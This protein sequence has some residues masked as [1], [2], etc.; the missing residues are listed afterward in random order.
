[1]QVD[2]DRPPVVPP[3]PPLMR[4]EEVGELFG[5]E[6]RQVSRDL[7]AG[8]LAGE[9]IKTP[10]GQWRIPRAAVQDFLVLGWKARVR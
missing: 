10:G 8:W 3:G 2:L 9:A 6:R 7:N 1:M 5:I 4:P